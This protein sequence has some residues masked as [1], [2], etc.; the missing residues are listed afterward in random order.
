MNLYWNVTAI[1]K[2]EEKKENARIKKRGLDRDAKSILNLI[3]CLCPRSNRQSQERNL[4]RS[5]IEGLKTDMLRFV[6]DIAV[7][8]ESEKDRTD[9]IAKR[10]KILLM[11]M[12]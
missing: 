7:I 8:S 6:D 4:C 10:N 12:T 11:D 2:T 1:I 5:K 9:A 3:Q